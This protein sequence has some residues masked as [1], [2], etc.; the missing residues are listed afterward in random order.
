MIAKDGG[1]VPLSSVASITVHVRDVNDNAPY[2][3][4]AS[5][6]LTFPE[7]TVKGTALYTVRAIDLDEDQ[8]LKYR[9][10]KS[11][12]NIFAL[13]DLGEQVIT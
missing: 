2:F 7:D 1:E 6:N 8:K 12:R 5:L 3:E 10:E 9:I 4:P 11:D 13:I